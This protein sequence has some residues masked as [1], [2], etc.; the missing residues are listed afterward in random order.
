M[1]TTAKHCDLHVTYLMTEVWECRVREEPVVL[2]GV[3]GRFS[4]LSSSDPEEETKREIQFVKEIHI[5]SS[6]IYTS[7]PALVPPLL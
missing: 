1:P 4:P 7:I 2:L 3:A 5:I 6:Y